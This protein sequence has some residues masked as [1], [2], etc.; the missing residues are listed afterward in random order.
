MLFVEVIVHRGVFVAAFVIKNKHN[1]SQT[2]NNLQKCVETVC[3][4]SVFIDIL[5]EKTTQM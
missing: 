2:K 4:M 1:S 5:C 3:L